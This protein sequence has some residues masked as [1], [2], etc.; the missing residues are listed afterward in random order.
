MENAVARLQWDIADY[1]K[2]LRFGGRHGPVNSPRPTKRSGFTSTPVPRYLGK[3]T[4]EQYRQ[5]FAAIACSNGWDDVTA[6]LQLLSH[7]DGDALNVTLLIPESQ[8]VAPGVLMNSLSEHY[9]SP[10]QL[11]EYKHQFRRAFCRPDDDPSIFPIELETLA[12]RAFVDIDSSIQIQMVR[13]RFIDGQAKCALRRHLDSFGPDTPMRNI[14]D[15]CR[16]WESHN[17]AAVRRH[18]DSDRNYTRAVYQV[19]EDS[20]SP[21]VSTESETLDE[22]IR[23]LLPTPKLC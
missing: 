5:V 13:D 22:V 23:R 18:D 3:S 15:S 14:V 6:A 11:A 4:W 19:M 16:V 12:R 1:R 10:G 2:E 17:E 8:R 9:G 7:L 20:Q 21:T